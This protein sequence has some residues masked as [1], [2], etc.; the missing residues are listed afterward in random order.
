MPHALVLHIEHS[1]AVLSDEF[2]GFENRVL[3]RQPSTPRVLGRVPTAEGGRNTRDFT[4][5]RSVGW[6][7]VPAAKEACQISFQGRPI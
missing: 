6:R 7:T 1:E 4:L 3:N 5:L 2:R